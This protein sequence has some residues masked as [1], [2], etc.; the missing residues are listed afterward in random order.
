MRTEQLFSAARIARM[1]TADQSGRPHLV[2]VVFTLADDTVYTCV[3]D[4]PKRTKALRR[5]DNIEANSRITILVD[6]Y[7][8]DW[9]N[10]WW[11]RVDGTAEI[12]EKGGAE[13]ERALDALSEKY[14]QYA[15]VRP[16]G[17]VIAVRNLRWHSWSGEGTASVN[18]ELS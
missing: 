17:P 10:L 8:E 3:D 16:P 7:E 12:L 4:K 15:L 13:S 11:V 5:L 14:P 6:H 9:E 2:P 18:E 1:A